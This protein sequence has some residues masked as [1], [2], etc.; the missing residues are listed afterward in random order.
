M[1]NEGHRKVNEAILNGWLGKLVRLTT[2]CV[3]WGEEY[4]LNVMASIR[5]SVVNS[6]ERS[7]ISIV[8]S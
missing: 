5:I 3:Q 2:W 4:L 8:V 7:F 1:A 6:L